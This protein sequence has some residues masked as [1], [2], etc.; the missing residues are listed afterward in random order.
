VSRRG[1]RAQPGLPVPVAVAIR[2]ANG[3]RTLTFR[4]T[5]GQ[6]TVELALALPLVVFLVLLVVQVGLV[7]ADQVLVVHAAREA[8]RTAA[9]S[10][11]GDLRVITQSAQRAGPLDPSRLQVE[12]TRN[13]PTEQSVRVHVSYRCRTAVVLLGAVIPDITL[14]AEAVMRSE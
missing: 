4:S 7:I 10:S 8:V 12:L 11:R 13:V 1:R 14:E 6:A 2:R 5:S 3:H 9:V